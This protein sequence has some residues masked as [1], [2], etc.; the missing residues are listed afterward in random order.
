MVRLIMNQDRLSRIQAPTGRILI[1]F[2]LALLVSMPAAAF[3]ASGSPPL[4]VQVTVK[5]IEFQS[6]KNVE[7]GLSAFFAK[8]PRALPF[9]R[10][11]TS[12]ASINTAD[13]TFPISTAA[14]GITV[15]LDRLRLTEG[16]IDFVL[17]GLVEESR[18]FILSRP[19]AMV[20]VGEATPMTVQTTLDLPYEDTLVVGATTVRVTKFRKTG[21]TLAISVPEVIDD[22]GD[23]NTTE[24]TYIRMDVTASVKEEG[25]RRTV[26]LEG[27]APIA[28]PEFINRSI[29][30]HVWVRENQ[31]LM[32]GGLYRNTKS[33]DLATLPW[34]TQAEDVGI[35]LIERIVP[36]NFLRSPV[37]SAI[38]NRS[39]SEER[40]E[41]VFL[42]KAEIW[43][44]FMTVSDG[45]RFDSPDV[46]S[47]TQTPKDIIVGVLDDIGSIPR[48]LFGPDEDAASDDVRSNLGSRR[49]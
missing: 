24:D 19:Q 23:W 47:K 43:R 4:Q 3:Q 20:M 26:A 5:I 14:A 7:S 18:A 11:R 12:G 33:R 41:L 32:M 6:S 2:A 38:G 21:V 30:T 13:L 44:P 29:D 42:I 35:G 46:E 31:V 40:R 16:D 8:L 15:F 25:Q 22:D 34:L 17:Q 37:S 27:G 49:R 39:K 28:V 45:L 48:R 1:V 10:V 36:G 9:G